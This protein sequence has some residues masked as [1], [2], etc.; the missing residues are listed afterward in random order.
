MAGRLLYRVLY[1]FRI[2][3][4][5]AEMRAARRE[6]ICDPSDR[7]KIR[8]AHEKNTELRVQEEKTEIIFILR[9]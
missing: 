3:W 6:L 8:D 4:D 5:A 2:Q 9:F 7:R 1:R